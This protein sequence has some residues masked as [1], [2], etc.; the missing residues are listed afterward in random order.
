MKP[1]P[2]KQA[3]KTDKASDSLSVVT[4]LCR[5]LTAVLKEP[6]PQGGRQQQP[7]RGWSCQNQSVPAS[8]V[9]APSDKGFL[10]AG[11]GSRPGGRKEPGKPSR[12]QGDAQILTGHQTLTREKVMV[13]GEELGTFC[14]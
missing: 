11:G 4:F 6:V 8:W 2:P 14:Q 5:E 7:D 3:R 1:D 10:K 9:T 12:G 13:S